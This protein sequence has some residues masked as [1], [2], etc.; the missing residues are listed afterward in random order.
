MADI[1]CTK[2]GEPWDIDTIHDVADEQGSTFDRVRK[3]FNRR[4]CV[5]LGGAACETVNTNRTAAAR[6]FTDLLGDDIDGI[7]AELA[8][9][10]YFGLLEG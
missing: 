2:C 9:A 4:G 5:A 8:D 6:A 10:E 1:F 3:D 7:A